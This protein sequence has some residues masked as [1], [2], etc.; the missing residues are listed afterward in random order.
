M[1]YKDSLSYH[2]D[3]QRKI[4]QNGKIIIMLIITNVNFDCLKS[5]FEYILILIILNY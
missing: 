4:Y 3:Y 2:L 1:N 5:V